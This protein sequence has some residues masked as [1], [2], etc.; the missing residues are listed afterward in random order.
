MDDS[1]IVYRNP[2]EKAFWE[3]NM[4]PVIAVFI[5]VMLIVFVV[6]YHGFMNIHRRWG[7]SPWKEPTWFAWVSGILSCAAAVATCYALFY[8]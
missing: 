1:I 2:L 3:S 4:L 8:R 7:G 6:V 5:I